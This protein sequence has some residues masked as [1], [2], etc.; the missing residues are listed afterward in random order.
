MNQQS[1]TAGFVLGSVLIIFGVL[2]LIETVIDLD[3]WIWVVILTV[4]AVGIY[5]I[6]ARD[7]SQKWL[8]IILSMKRDL[9][10]L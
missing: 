9:T 8:L 2:A 4:G 10:I 5:F 6:Y 1:R 3:A 7:R